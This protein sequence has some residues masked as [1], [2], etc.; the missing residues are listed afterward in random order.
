SG[1]GTIVCRGL[2]PHMRTNPRRKN[3][4]VATP[5]HNSATLEQSCTVSDMGLMPYRQAWDLQGQLV[6]QRNARKVQDVLLLLE[7]PPVI[8]VGRNAKREHL[9]ASVETLEHEGIELLETDRG[10]DI[11][12][13]GPGQLVA[14]PILDLSLI[15]RDV[16][17]Y[18]RTLEEAIIR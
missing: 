14:Y 5:M 18:V 16:V 6:A 10:G 17:W 4:A 9:L 13:H 12:F 3:R 8:T 15:R 1:H 11:T 7:H 2:F